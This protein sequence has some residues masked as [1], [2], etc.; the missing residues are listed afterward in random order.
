MS[1]NLRGD[2]LS[3]TVDDES[4][5]ADGGSLTAGRLAAGGLSSPS[6]SSSSSSASSAD[7]LVDVTG[8][9]TCG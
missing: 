9:N 5:S 6:S 8:A 3:H 4:E 2:F 1:E 7:L